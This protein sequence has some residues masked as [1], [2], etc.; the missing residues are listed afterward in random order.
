MIRRMILTVVMLTATIAV[1]S[2]PAYA[3]TPVSKACTQ[4]A[5]NASGV[6]ALIKC[7]AP[8]LGVST[9]TA[10]AVAWR[11]S[12]YQPGARNPSSGT[13]GVFQHMPRYWPERVRHFYWGHDPS[14]FNGRTNVL[15]SLRMV[16]A[17]GWGPWGM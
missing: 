2:A 6:K 10:L 7:A 11:E 12:H 15:V 3:A 4:P 8:R 17:G 13:C 9:S 1:L 5:K 16:R 14:C